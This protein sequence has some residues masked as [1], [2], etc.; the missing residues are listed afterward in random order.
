M[1]PMV[2]SDMRIR[3]SVPRKIWRISLTEKPS[4]NPLKDPARIKLVPVAEAQLK[5]KTAGS[6]CG[7]ATTGG[8]RVTALCRTGTVKLID[9][10]PLRAFGAVFGPPFRKVFTGVRPHT[11]TN[12]ESRIQ[13][14]QA[15][16]LRPP[17]WIRRLACSVARSVWSSC[18]KDQTVGGCQNFSRT[19][20]D[21]METSEAPMAASEGPMKLLMTYCVPPK[22]M[23]AVKQA[24]QTSIIFFRPHI[25]HTTQ[26]GMARQ[27]ST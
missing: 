25:A 4:S 14:I 21:T 20:S 2:S 16:S 5:T 22:V 19:T 6:C 7:L 24:G 18:S 1:A 17:G 8:V 10:M 13:G 12:A 3:L 15:F 23:P 11:K 9:E 27:N 26:N